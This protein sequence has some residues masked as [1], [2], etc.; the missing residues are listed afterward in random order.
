MR[1]LVVAGDRAVFEVTGQIGGVPAVL[2]GTAADAGNPGRDGDTFS[3]RITAAAGGSLLY[4]S[5]QV[6]LDNGNL[7]V[8]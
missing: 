2:R 4:E 5:G 7:N 8:G 6:E 3:V 1:W